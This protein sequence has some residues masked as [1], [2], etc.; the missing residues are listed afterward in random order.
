MKTELS[1]SLNPEITVQTNKGIT[2][3]VKN[4]FK[5]YREEEGFKLQVAMVSEMRPRARETM[6]LYGW[7]G[8]T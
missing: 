5:R 8:K 7:T 2:E 1:F 4:G 6:G 3:K